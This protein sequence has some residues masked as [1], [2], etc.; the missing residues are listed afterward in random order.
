MAATNAAALDEP[1]WIC[2]AGFHLVGSLNVRYT[3]F[4]Q[5]SSCGL[6]PDQL[7][8]GLLRGGTPEGNVCFQIP[9]VECIVN[10]R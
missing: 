10:G 2:D 9:D 1:A 8:G 3:T 4:G 7:T 5:D 6:V